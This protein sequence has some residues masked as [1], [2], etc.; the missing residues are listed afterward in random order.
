MTA[1]PICI[2]IYANTQDD[3]DNVK[4]LLQQ[5]LSEAKIS[6]T[7]RKYA[8]DVGQVENLSSVQVSIDHKSVTFHPLEQNIQSC[9]FLRIHR[10]IISKCIAVLKDCVESLYNGVFHL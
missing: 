4:M 7:W 5:K 1:E 6:I 2:D 10:N 9:V 8:G 3:I